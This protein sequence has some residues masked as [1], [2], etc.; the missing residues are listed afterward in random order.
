M[1]K[2]GNIIFFKNQLNELDFTLQKLLPIPVEFFHSEEFGLIGDDWCTAIW[3][4]KW[5]VSNSRISESGDTIS[6]FY[7][8]ATDSNAKWVEAFC[9]YLNVTTYVDNL[10]GD[11]EISVTHAI[12]RL[13]DDFGCKMEWTPEKGHSYMEGEIL[14]W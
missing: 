5:D 13:Y 12:Y 1:E 7:L 6:I 2:I 8:T 3:G 11:I 14:Y 10:Q 9:R 4:T